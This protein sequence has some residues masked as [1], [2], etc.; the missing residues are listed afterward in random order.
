MLARDLVERVL[1][2]G[3]EVLA[4]FPGSA[5]S[6][7][8][9][10]PPFRYVT[11]YGPRGHTVL[12]GD[13]VTTTDGTGIVH[14]AIAFGEDDFRLGEE[15]GI[16][17]QN[18]VRADGTFDDRVTDFAGRSRQ[19]RRP[20]HR[21][22][23]ARERPA[24]ARGG[25]RARLSPLLALRHTAALLRQVELVHP[26]HRAFATGCWRSTRASA[27][28]PT[29]SRP[30]A[31]GAGSRATSTGRSRASATGAR[32]CR[33]G[34]ASRPSASERFCAGSIAE[35]RE[36]GADVPDDL[37]RPFIDEVV[38]DCG[39]CGRE[40]RRVEEVIDAWF[41]SGRDAVRAVS[42]PVRERGPV[43]RA[44]PGGLHL[45]GPGPDPRLVLLAARRVDPALRSLEL[46]RTA[47]ASA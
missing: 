19:G 10:E 27:G 28:A 33:S 36:R 7:V 45:R 37:H 44:L 38:V 4:H 5:L 8:R 17:L 16:T 42:L 34:N 46:S 32:R 47:S 41:D 23:A 1:G 24:A 29:T 9:Y 14:T 13:F 12:L 6:G 43:R 25:L 3:A 30:G 20:R 22:G 11:D 21:R 40:M 35:L 31:S 26:H 18:P 2:E 15:Y 39:S